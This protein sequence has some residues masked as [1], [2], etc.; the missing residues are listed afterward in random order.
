M[1]TSHQQSAPA[2]SPHP[3]PT[4]DGPDPLA[5]ASEAARRLVDAVCHVVRGSESTIRLVTCALL[6]GGHVLVEDLP[7]TGKTT[8]ARAFARS[9]GGTFAR[10]QATADLMPADITGSGIWEPAHGGFR[11]VAGPVFVN[12]LVID[13][14]NRTSPRTQSAFMEA[15]DEG[16]ITVDGVR[17]ALPDPFFALATQ[18]PGEQHGTFPL[19]EGEL[20]RFAVAV[21]LGTLD[22]RTELDVVREQLVRPTVDDLPPVLSPDQLRSVRAAVRTTHVSEPVLTHAVQLARATRSDPRVVH[23]VS[24]RAALSLVRTAQAHAVLQG[25]AFVTPDDTKAVAVAALAHRLV[26]RGSGSERTAA[27]AL[28]EDL[29]GRLPVPL[30]PTDS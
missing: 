13:E 20:D 3:A 14:L 4:T 6:A 22:L 10:V 9:I 26:L 18:N 24:S 11:F 2:P 25:R 5:Q 15:L 1:S 16:A 17:H 19:P 7:G 30:A 23:G 28:V 29:L 12:V 27:V 21:G 8:M